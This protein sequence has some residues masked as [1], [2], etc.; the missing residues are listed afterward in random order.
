[1]SCGKTIL[2]FFLPLVLGFF[3]G[4]YVG[5]HQIQRDFPWNL[6]NNHCVVLTVDA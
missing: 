3:V 2:I 1:M 5:A 6:V 4:R